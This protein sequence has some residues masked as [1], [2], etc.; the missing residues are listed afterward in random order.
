MQSGFERDILPTEQHLVYAGAVLCRE[1]SR[2][3]G[4]PSSPWLKIVCEPNSRI[5]QLSRSIPATLSETK[6]SG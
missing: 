1:L 4:L 6:G 2:I 5:G 3:A